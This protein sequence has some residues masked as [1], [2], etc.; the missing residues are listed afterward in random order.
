MS[1][2]PIVVGKV[3]DVP[4]GVW[5]AVGREHFEK[6]ALEVLRGDVLHFY[7][8]M[9]ILY[10]PKVVNVE[11]WRFEEVEEPVVPTP[12]TGVVEPPCVE[13]CEEDE[14]TYASIY[15]EAGVQQ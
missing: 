14:A 15:V 7:G 13:R 4:I 3:I 5:R 11:F 9:S 12:L 10:G 1:P 2:K 8:E 6:L